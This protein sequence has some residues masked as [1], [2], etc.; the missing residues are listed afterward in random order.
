VL[1]LDPNERSKIVEAVTERL[2]KRAASAFRR[3]GEAACREHT[4][5]TLDALQE[6]LRTG[7]REA[8]RA[9]ANTLTD[10]LS[11]EGLNFSDVRFFSQTLRDHV[12][13]AVTD[14]ARLA[15]EDWFFEH[16]V[17]S[18]TRYIV[19]RE[20]QQQHEAAK[21]GIARV[22]SQLAELEQALTEKTELLELVREASTPIAPVVRGIL[23]VPLVGVFDAFR[24]EALTE[25]LLHEL[26]RVHARAAILDISGVP[27]FDSRAAQ[28]IISLARSV[29]LLGAEVYLVG[30]SPRNAKTIVELGVDLSHLETLATLQAGLARALVAQGL[31]IVPC[32]SAGRRG[33]PRRH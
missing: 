12:R 13:A 1:I 14:D 10:A 6:D 30:M 31:E 4:Q 17:V 2:A 19:W 18:T 24:A 5:A 27:V 33:K 15:I 25:K 32:R 9:A 3:L 11:S 8:L 28:L 21:R 23:V 16:V 7:Q 22:E 26:T 20:E 29:R